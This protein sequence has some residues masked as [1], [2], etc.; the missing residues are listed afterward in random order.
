MAHNINIFVFII[1][2][3][4]IGF[5][6]HAMGADVSGADPNLNAD[7]NK[8]PYDPNGG[9][10]IVH[11][12]KAWALAC[13]ALLIEH[14]WDKHDSLAPFRMKSSNIEKMKKGLSE[15]W[16]ITDRKSF[17]ETMQ[18]IERSGHRKQFDYL[19][20]NTA[21]LD[22]FEFT[23]LCLQMID[24]DCGNL[25]AA[26]EWYPKL[27]S[28]SLIGWDFSR[29]IWL[30]RGA[31]VCGYITEEEAWDMIMHYAKILQKTFDSWD[32][33]GRN[34]LIGRRFWSYAES[35]RTG[36]EFVE[37]YTRLTQMPTSPWRTLDWNMDLNQ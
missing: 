34:Y 27:K 29:A 16:D 7:P 21:D 20:E 5:R 24:K 33:L 13:S 3:V 35:R 4:I 31:Y 26:R 14:N 15:W 9:R 28:K 36:Y 18:W 1:L 8:I 30:C 32:D 12:G 22:L 10:K 37:Y 6:G 17:F 11:G 25:V 2:L 19:G 23:I